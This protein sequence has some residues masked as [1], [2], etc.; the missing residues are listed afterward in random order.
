MSRIQLSNLRIAGPIDRD[1]PQ[2]IADACRDPSETVVSYPLRTEDLPVVA[3]FLNPD[4]DWTEESLEEAFQH[5]LPFLTPLNAVESEDYCKSGTPYQ[6]GRPTPHEPKLLNFCCLYRI[7]RLHQI[8]TTPST[9]ITHLLRMHSMLHKS[10]PYLRLKITE[11]C[12]PLNCLELI[13]T[14]AVLP[15]FPQ[16]SPPEPESE[17]ALGN[18]EYENLLEHIS[19]FENKSTLLRRVQPLSSGEA[20]VLAAINYHYDLTDALYPIYEYAQ[21]S[22]DAL[23]YTPR[24]PKMLYKFRQDEYAYRLDYKFNPRLPRAFYP[25]R[26]LKDLAYEEGFLDEDFRFSEPYELLQFA[27]VSETFYHGKYTTITNVETPLL[28]DTLQDLDASQVICYGV[29]DESLV[30]FTYLELAKFFRQQSS[31]QNPLAPSETLETRSIRKIKRLCRYIRVHETDEARAARTLLFDAIVY[32][33][34]FMQEK[35]QFGQRLLAAYREATEEDR[36]RY[37]AIF[38]SLLEL[39]MY[40]RGWSGSGPFP[41]SEAPV[42][43]QN[44]V[45]VNVTQALG[46]FEE[47]CS[48]DPNPAA[49]I[50]ALPLLKYR[51]GRFVAVS[52]SAQGQTIG[53]RLALV[54]LGETADVLVS[55]IR[56]TSNLLAAS[57]YRYSDILSL[58]VPF[59]IHR[60]RM[61]S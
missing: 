5:L 11:H 46:R 49:R 29:R 7:C 44:Q 6:F 26:S 31:F 17:Y 48:G 35:G 39:C 8:P 41:I 51:D 58:P 2:V 45:D 22:S 14:L 34:L 50:L 4:V 47:V 18:A 52:D 36:D 57:L 59:E 19:T 42:D 60:L 40:M 16:N 24:D 13:A 54:K 28:Y 32:V 53:S 23:N 55:C 15:I 61:I 12:Q 30:A 25:E 43:C 27:Y 10:P 38:Q 37:R 20:C 33:E 56:L 1:T 9:T 21:L 3:A